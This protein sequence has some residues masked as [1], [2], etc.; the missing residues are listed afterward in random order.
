MTDKLKLYTTGIEV[1][2]GYAGNNEYGWAA[3]IHWFCLEHMSDKSINGDIYTTYSIFTIDK[4][5]D[6]IL[7]MI[8]R[9]GIMP[10]PGMPLSL[11]R[12]HMDQEEN[13][14]EIMRNEAKRRGWTCYF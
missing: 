4:A 8:N 3:K 7:D 2:Y 1:D 6:H 9:F 5:I 13:I 10:V 14:N 12:K 11:F